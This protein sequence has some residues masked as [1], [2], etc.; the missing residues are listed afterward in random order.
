M[1]NPVVLEMLM[2]SKLAEEVM[3]K[4]LAEIALRRADAKFKAMIK[5]Q[6]LGAPTGSEIIPEKL[7]PE[8]AKTSISDKSISLN[9]VRKTMHTIEQGT[10]ML[11]ETARN[12]ATQVDGIYH[13]VNSVM[14]IS[15]LNTGISLANT[16]VDVAGFVVVTQKLNVL[17]NEVQLVANKIS[18]VAN[19]QKNEKIATCQKLI[20]RCNSMI[21][22]LNNDEEVDLDKMEN[23]LIDLRAFV[24]EMIMNLHDMALG[25]NLVLKMIYTLLP[26]YTLLFNEFL[27]RYY[28][29]KMSVPINYEMF[30]SL[31]EELE[32]VGF[33]QKLQDY[34]YLQE[35]MRAVDVVDILNAQRL[36]GL[37]GKVQI[38]DQLSVF[39]TLESK[40]KVMLF[41]K[42]LNNYAENRIKHEFCVE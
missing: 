34:Y 18:Q 24:S 16:A 3:E 25:E 29:Q 9:A 2:D 17:N 12:I 10:G 33:I 41:E 7:M 37:N 4:G 11:T 31:Y 27:R 13:Q 35:K 8:L 21:D 32:N 15:Y 1:E 36:I 39:R 5:C 14:N 23:L 20:M 42:S 6:V 19:V 38:E 30:M 40:E 22:K 26:A 28:F